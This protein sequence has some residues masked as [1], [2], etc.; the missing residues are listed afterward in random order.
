[1]ETVK[2]ST[3]FN[4]DVVLVEGRSH[5]NSVEDIL[6]DLG[7]YK[8]AE[9]YTTTVIH[10]NFNAKEIME[11][12]IEDQLCNG[13]YDDWDDSIRGDITNDD[14][15]ELQAIFDRIIARNPGCN[16]AYESD[17]L[18]EIDISAYCPTCGETE[19]KNAKG[20]PA[21][22]KCGRVATEDEMA[23]DIKTRFEE[24]KKG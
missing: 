4:N 5:V 2:L 10:A 20:K 12:A 19:Y 14:I 3:L 6:S 17:K 9:I 22:V 8:D 7:S 16:I 11:A 18:I 21:C 23:A 15:M 13:M 1:M 24:L